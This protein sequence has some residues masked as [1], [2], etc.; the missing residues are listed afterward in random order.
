MISIFLYIQFIWWCFSMNQKSWF[1]FLYLFLEKFWVICNRAPITSE[2]TLS[3]SKP[4][5]CKVLLLQCI[6]NELNCLR[7]VFQN[8][9]AI[10]RNR[11]FQRFWQKINSEKEKTQNHRI[12]DYVIQT[13]IKIWMQKILFGKSL[14]AY[15]T[16]F[17]VEQKKTNKKMFGANSKILFDKWELYE[18][19]FFQKTKTSVFLLPDYVVRIKQLQKLVYIFFQPFLEIVWKCM[20]SIFPHLMYGIVW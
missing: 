17:A 12:Q 11:K 5:S 8:K 7:V 20:T 15:K 14:F 9:H 1:L 13:K 4:K 10:N 6:E 3:Y 16:R 18:K 19:L 2:K